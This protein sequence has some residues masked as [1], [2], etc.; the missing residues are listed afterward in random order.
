VHFY[1]FVCDVSNLE[2]RGRDS[3]ASS[4]SRFGHVHVLS[5]SS[6]SAHRFVSL[7]EPCESGLRP[8]LTSRCIK[9]RP[10]LFLG[11]ESPYIDESAHNS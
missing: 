11:V 3:F 9:S 2:S 5:V 1:L 8:R 6:S 7:P 10:V 4:S